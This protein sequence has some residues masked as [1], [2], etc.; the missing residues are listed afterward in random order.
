MKFLN[1]KEGSTGTE[2]VVFYKDYMA[3]LEKKEKSE[4]DIQKGN[5]FIHNNQ[6]LRNNNKDEI[7]IPKF[8]LD[9]EKTDKR[10][11]N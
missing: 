11:T 9:E 5:N 7:K 10:I 6:G 8:L 1:K 4:E 2:K 3:N